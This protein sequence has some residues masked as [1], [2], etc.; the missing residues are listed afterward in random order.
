M[1]PK[2]THR[3]SGTISPFD[4]SGIPS[5]LITIADTSKNYQDKITAMHKLAQVQNML[6]LVQTKNTL[7]DALL[8]NSSYNIILI[9]T[10]GSI[11][12]ANNR[13]KKLLRLDLG[14][15]S[16]K[17]YKQVFTIKD[18]RDVISY[19]IIESAFNGNR[20]RFPTWTFIDT[21]SAKIAVWGEVIPL[22]NNNT[23]D[24]AVIF[25]DVTQKYQSDI[26]DKAF[27]TGAAHDLR[28]PISAIRGTLELVNQ[29]PSP[30]PEDTK[31]K[32]LVGAYDSVMFLIT[33]VNDLLNVSRLEQG[34]IEIKKSAIDVTALVDEVTEQLSLMAKK[35]ELYLKVEPA[36]T[37]MQRAWADLIKTREILHNLISN[38]IKYTLQGGVTVKCY[39][40][41]SQIKIQ[42]ADSGFGI[43]PQHQSILFKKFQQ[44]GA[45]RGQSVAKSIGLGLYISKRFAQIMGGDVYLVSSELEK[46]SV[47]EVSLPIAPK[48]SQ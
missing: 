23:Y 11:Y 46:G 27:F 42:V 3:I 34:K 41:D 12:Y 16:V 40:K 26:E 37:G 28:T 45:A 5:T 31:Q 21:T 15:D 13:A 6:E 24:V 36:Q 22:S 48:N 30:I 1:T 20:A 4:F 9:R 35:K 33:L 39:E 19:A 18:E 47:F 7:A 17:N 25:E 2:Q 38:A 8:E 32:L 14:T 29:T 10:D 44:V 43:S